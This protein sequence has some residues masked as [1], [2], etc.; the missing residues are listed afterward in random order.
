M[1]EPACRKLVSRA[2]ARIGDDQVRYQPTRENQEELV[3]A[4]DTIRTGRPGMYVADK[5]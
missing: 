1:S 4:L 5:D 3:A 2:K